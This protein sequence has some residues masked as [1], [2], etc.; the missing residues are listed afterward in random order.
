[1]QRL[2]GGAVERF[3]QAVR[4]S[5]GWIDVPRHASRLRGLIAHINPDV[6]HA[7]RIPFEG[8]LASQ[9][10]MGN[11]V[12]LVLSVWGNDFTYFA[13]K[14]PMIRRLTVRALARA[15]GLHTDCNRDQQLG[16]GYGFHRDRPAT[17]LPGAGGV[18]TALFSP[19][20][21]SPALRERFN[22]R[23]GAKIV[24]NP[25]GFRGYVRN[26]V[27]F[28]AAARVLEVRSEVVFVALGMMGVAVAERW[29]RAQRIQS[30]T[31]LLA[32]LDK[33]ELA[34]LLR[35]SDVMVSPSE[36]DGTPN[37]LL[38]AM[39]SGT[40]PIVGDLPS[41]REWIVHG[42][43]GL[44]IDQRDPQALAT[45]ILGAL[46]AEEHRALAAAHNVR[47]VKQRA[48][49]QVV[50]QSAEEFYRRVI[51]S[52]RGKHSEGVVNASTMVRGAS[53]ASQTTS[54]TYTEEEALGRPGSGA[55]D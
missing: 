32:T 21:P 15:D 20:P 41:L 16:F 35:E 4:F 31:R 27:F 36:H 45:A 10:L 26:D 9:A 50:M 34:S 43:N 5:A 11:P 53:L 44:L 48:D 2:R 6:V 17:V 49:R 24:T 54:L 22:I 12:P 18:D 47:L 19:G 40:F 39:A 52:C 8:L 30:G 29:V 33:P 38:E 1:V 7:M 25:R 13:A 28:A 51:D 23:T 55:V 42:E 3:A 14:Y 46:D 37:S